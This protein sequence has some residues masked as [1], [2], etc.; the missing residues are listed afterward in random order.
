MFVREDVEI[1][2]ADCLRGIAQAKVRGERLA[3][4][5]E[6]TVHVLEVDVVRRVV[7]ERLQQ[8]P[9]LNEIRFRA[10]PLG[11][12]ANGQHETGRHPVVAPDEFAADL[13]RKGAA[14]LAHRAVFNRSQHLAGEYAGDVGDGAVTVLGDDE[15]G[16]GLADQFRFAVPAE[17]R[18]DGRGDHENAAHQIRHDHRNLV[19]GQA[20]QVRGL[21]AA[22]V[23]QGIPRDGPAR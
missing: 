4:H 9:F 1:R 21:H 6:A 16:D 20:H 14:V 23:L 3:D 18:D 11:H 5:D 8:R 22:V 2:F 13:H 10:L 19:P 17:H 7:Q 12:L 15:F